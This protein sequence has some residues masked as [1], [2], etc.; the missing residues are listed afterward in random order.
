VRIDLELQKAELQK[1][2][3]QS[4]DGLRRLCD[5]DSQGR[6]TIHNPIKVGL[7]GK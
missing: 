6:K 2:E 1:A 4:A 7:G 5:G 3:L